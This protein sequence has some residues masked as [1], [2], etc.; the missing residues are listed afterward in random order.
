MEEQIRG[1]KKPTEKYFTDH[2]LDSIDIKAAIQKDKEIPKIQ[3]SLF[4]Y[5]KNENSSN[6]LRDPFN[7]DK[8]IFI[9]YNLKETYASELFCNFKLIG[10]GAFGSVFSAYDKKSKKKVAIKIISK[11]EYSEVNHEII[12]SEVLIQSYLE[13]KNIAKLFSVKENDNYMFLIMEFIE[14]GSLKDLIFERYY[15]KEPFFKE[16]ECSTIIKN[17]LEGLFYIHGKKIMH[18]DIKPENILFSDKKDYNTLKI[19]DFGL[20]VYSENDKENK[21]CGTLIFKS[22]ELINGGYYDHCIDLWATGFILY[23][24]CS[25]GSHPIYL[26]NNSEQYIDAIKNWKRWNFPPKFPKLA[27]NLF[28]KIC[29]FNKIFRYEGG[30]SLSHPWITRNADTVI[31]QTLL[32]ICQRKELIH[33]FK[34]LLSSSIVFSVFK[35]KLFNVTRKRS[36]KSKKVFPK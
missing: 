8:A 31:P 9:S 16:S 28:I 7:W 6:K 2:I 34:I 30:K 20:A 14:G 29:K 1:L 5:R 11:S 24:L 19:V 27:R 10:Q 18:R 23:I 21:E 3:E 13:H 26:K 17:I 12:K 25:G 32:D 33:Q 4:L 35:S 22:P 15:S 36:S